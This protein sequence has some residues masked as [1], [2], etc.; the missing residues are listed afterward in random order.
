MLDTLLNITEDKSEEINRDQ[1]KH[2]FLDLF[3]A[4]TDTTSSTLE[5]AMTELIRNPKTLSKARLELEQTI[6][7]GNQFEESDV[8]RLPYLQAI[9]K[10]TLRLHS[11][12]PLLLPRK[13][14]SNV[15]ICGYVV[16]EG[17]QVLVNAWAIGRDGTTWDKPDSFVPERFLG[18]DVDV[19][20]RNFE[21]IPFGAGRR[22]CPGLPLAMRMLY[23]MLGTLINSFDWKLEGGLK[24]EKMDMDDKFGITIQR[25]QPLHAIPVAL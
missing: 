8:S 23:L 21:V 3:A 19:K 13:S 14:S 24:P 12:I 7:K 16:P 11:P 22:I 25:A 4:G 2:L 17:A 9:V 6:G 15:E 10:E 5:W 18:L 20:G 1:I